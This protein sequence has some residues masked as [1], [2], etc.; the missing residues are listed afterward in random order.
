MSSFQQRT[1]DLYRLKTRSLVYQNPNGTY[2]RKGAVG[3]VG[4]TVGNVGWSGVTADSSGNLTIPGTTNMANGAVIVDGT[5]GIVTTTQG[6]NVGG[7]LSALTVTTNALYLNN[8][9]NPTQQTQLFVGNDASGV[10][11]LSWINSG[12]ATEPISGIAPRLIPSSHVFR[13]IDVTGLTGTTLALAQNMNALLTLLQSRQCFVRNISDITG[14]VTMFNTPVSIQFTVRDSNPATPDII[15]TIVQPGDSV[16]SYSTLADT[17]NATAVAF[18]APLTATFWA[19]ATWTP[20]IDGNITQTTSGISGTYRK[21]GV[22]DGVF[23]CYVSSDISYLEDVYMSCTPV[24]IAAPNATF[25]FAIGFSETPTTV[26]TGGYPDISYGFYVKKYSSPSYDIFIIESGVVSTIFTNIAGA[27]GP[28]LYMSYTGGTVNYFVDG[29]Q[30]SSTGRAVSATPLFLDAKIAYTTD[31][32]TNLQFGELAAD[33]PSP[34]NI[35]LRTTQPGF[36][37]RYSD[38]AT[39]GTA[40]L[41]MNHLGFTSASTNIFYDGLESA[42]ADLAMDIPDAPTGAP[43]AGAITTTTCAINI[44]PP[45]TTIQE[46]CIY[47]SEVDVSF[48]LYPNDIVSAGTSSYNITGLSPGVMYKVGLSYRSL[49]DETPRGPL[50]NITTVGLAPLLRQFTTGFS[51]EITEDVNWVA[52]PSYGVNPPNYAKPFTSNVRFTVA[53]VF[54]AIFNGTLGDLTN[55]N[56]IKSVTL[57]IYAGANASRATDARLFAGKTLIWTASQVEP[58]YGDSVGVG[59]EIVVDD[60]ACIEAI[61]NADTAGNIDITKNISFAWLCS[62]GGIRNCEITR[63]SILYSV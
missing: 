40:Q 56:Q 28:T 47:W 55:I 4:D 18:G 3:Y 32:I 50:L 36:S 53:T 42:V 26:L 38:I 33:A 34:C 48:N 57:D 27:I 24:S 63:F 16:V 12:G 8:I 43:T 2:P 20:V 35:V 49:Y 59:G 54:P 5:S 37:F 60:A 62:T 52:T 7:P 41:F 15:F 51:V 44:P 30:F 1:D 19:P 23:D 6:V 22:V 39:N 13:A 11:T 58:K 9:A 61:F 46:I 25:A 31:S 29:I 10:E 45:P 14:I 21:T 17:I